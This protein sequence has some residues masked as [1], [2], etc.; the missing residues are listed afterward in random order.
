MSDLAHYHPEQ[1]GLHL[2]NAL[3][4]YADDP[5]WALSVRRKWRRR[6]ELNSVGPEKLSEEMCILKMQMRT[7]LRTRRLFIG[8]FKVG[9]DK[10]RFPDLYW[11]TMA[12]LDRDNNTASAHGLTLCDVR[13]FIPDATVTRALP[14]DES[15]GQGQ[16]CALADST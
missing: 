6:T 4:V 7:A 13:I 10:L 11:C 2:Q 16:T 9:E 14:A 5:N 8:G 15:S 1:E 12:D 3:F